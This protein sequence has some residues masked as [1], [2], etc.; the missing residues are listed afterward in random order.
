MEPLAVSPVWQVRN[1]ARHAGQDVLTPSHGFTLIE[2][3]VVVVI[4]GI[5]LSLV[6]VNFSRD[7]RQVLADEAQRLGLLLEHAHDESIASSRAFA[8]I[9]DATSYRF[10]VAGD[11]GVFVNVGND[12]LLRSRE[13]GPGVQFGGIRVMRDEGQRAASPRIAFSPS[14]FISPFDIL[15]TAGDA[16]AV[17]AGSAAGRITVTISTPAGA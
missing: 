14:G 6:V 3:L 12:D 17:I 7:D 16:R 1:R 11:D 9:A 2:L 8:W 13:W 5:T 10:A 15:L 4:V